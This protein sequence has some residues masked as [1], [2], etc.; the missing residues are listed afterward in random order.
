MTWKEKQ[1]GDRTNVFDASPERAR[2]Y[3]LEKSTTLPIIGKEPG[4]KPFEA[5]KA[6]PVRSP[7]IYEAE[8]IAKDGD[9]VFHFWPEGYHKAEEEGRNPP[10][11]PP[12]FSK[13]MQSAISKVMAPSKVD[14][15]EDRDMGAWFVRVHGLATKPFQ[16][17]LCVKACE[18]V[19]KAMGGKAD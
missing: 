11:F 4:K 8:F 18:E 17:D 9:V 15:S 7:G 2:L 5:V 6:Q 10:H 12:T 14:I 16:F 1:T 19:H 13:A 3:D